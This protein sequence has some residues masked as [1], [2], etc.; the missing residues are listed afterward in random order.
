VNREWNETEQTFH[1]KTSDKMSVVSQEEITTLFETED[2]GSVFL[3]NVG[4]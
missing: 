2:D 4:V 1:F 3:K